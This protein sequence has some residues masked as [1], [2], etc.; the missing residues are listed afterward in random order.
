MNLELYVNGG[1]Y[2]KRLSSL[3]TMF[4]EN[5]ACEDVKF[6]VFCGDGK[7][8]LIRKIGASDS[9]AIIFIYD[10]ITRKSRTR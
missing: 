4:G 6:C 2:R 1:K 9:D 8:R 10:W 3:P 7:N 5:G